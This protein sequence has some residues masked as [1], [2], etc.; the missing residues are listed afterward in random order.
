MANR[1]KP[2][3]EEIEQFLKI[4]KFCWDG[5]VIPRA[6]PKNDETLTIIGITPKHRMEEIK[7][8]RYEDYSEGPS[9][10]YD[11]K[12]P[13]EWWIFGR[14]VKKYEIYI[15]IC[16]NKNPV[17]QYRAECMSFHIAE[18]KINYPF[19]ERS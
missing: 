15:K 8:L 18:G 17:G 11:S 9:P 6:H 3:K 2:S 12:Y 10:D 7:C 19:K 4:F 5:K 16:I 13:K 14:M 1:D